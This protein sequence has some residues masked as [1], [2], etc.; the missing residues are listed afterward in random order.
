MDR[1]RG[2]HISPSTLLSGSTRRVPL[3]CVAG[4]G[5]GSSEPNPFLEQHGSAPQSHLS[6][7][8]MQLQ[9]S[10]E[11]VH[12]HRS[13]SGT[14][15][16]ES[17]EW[18]SPRKPQRKLCCPMRELSKKQRLGVGVRF[19]AFAGIFISWSLLIMLLYLFMYLYRYIAERVA[20]QF[21]RGI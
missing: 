2:S 13:E 18:Q 11:A 16:N 4:K 9:I 10:Q 6:T 19:C 5:K 14:A 8:H 20:C 3:T 1:Q 17:L 12:P 15:Q 21:R 7:N